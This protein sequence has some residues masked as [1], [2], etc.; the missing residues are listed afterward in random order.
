MDDRDGGTAGDESPP[1]PAEPV[2]N[3]P[4]CISP[5]EAGFTTEA[6]H[7]VAPPR[8]GDGSCHRVSGRNFVD[9]MV[10]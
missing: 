7:P 1:H 5:E 10:L 4:W 8:V 2:E 3:R 6:I 9:P